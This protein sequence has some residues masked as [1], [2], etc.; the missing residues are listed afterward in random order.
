M[1]KSMPNSLP[2][3][4]NSV[5]FSFTENT[6]NMYEYSSIETK[7]KSYHSVLREILAKTFLGGNLV[8]W[9]LLSPVQISPLFRHTHCIIIISRGST[10]LSVNLLL[11]WT[12]EALSSWIGGSRTTL[13]L[14]GLQS[15]QSGQP[16]TEVN[17][18]ASISRCSS[19]V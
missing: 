5:P 6:N 19:N 4:Y 9:N 12:M 16:A 11:K 18:A 14:R 3:F 2:T 1:F 13:Y 17:M 7:R 10:Y 15:R 8:M